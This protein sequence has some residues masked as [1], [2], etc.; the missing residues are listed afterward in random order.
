MRPDDGS[1]VRGMTCDRDRH[2]AAQIRVQ[3]ALDSIQEA[4]RLIQQATQTLSRVDGMIPES[5]NL[6]SLS[7]RLTQTWYAV[8]AGANRLR[9]KGHL[10]LADRK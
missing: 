6:R 5:R 3:L 10:A 2:A 7:D 4:Q 1:H 8:S 9:R